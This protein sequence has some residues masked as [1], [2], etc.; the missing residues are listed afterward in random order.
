[1]KTSL[2]PNRIPSHTRKQSDGA[3]S[4]ALRLCCL[5][6][7]LSSI[8]LVVFLLQATLS[9]SSPGLAPP[10]E[11]QP[12]AL[13]NNSLHQRNLS[14]AERHTYQLDLVA[15]QFFRVILQHSGIKLT[16][17]L[18][19]PDGKLF[20]T[21]RGHQRG[22]LPISMTVEKT[23]V[24][25]LE[26]RSLEDSPYTGNYSLQ[27]VEKRAK[28][29]QDENRVAAD[30]AFAEAENDCST[31]TR[32]TLLA[33]KLQYQEAQQQ[34]QYS[35]ENKEEVPAL[36]SLG[37]VHQ[38]LGEKEQAQEALQRAL[39][40]VNEPALKIEIENDIFSLRRIDDGRCKQ[41]LESSRKQGFKRAEAL[42]LDNLGEM[43]YDAGQ[44]RLA[45]DYHLQ[46]LAL[47]RVLGERR[48]QALALW[49][50][51]AISAEFAETA[52]A[53]DFFQQAVNLY[54]VMEDKAGLAATLASMGHQE[55]WLGNKQQAMQC[56][57]QALQAAATAGDP[58]RKISISNGIGFFYTSFGEYA[59][60]LKQYEK[61]LQVAEELRR[62]ISQIGA[63]LEIG[64][65]YLFLEQPDQALA[66][67]RKAL[68]LSQKKEHHLFLPNVFLN[69]GMAY[70][71]KKQAVPA[72][73]ML[74][75]AAGLSQQNHDLRSAAR[76]LNEMG[77]IYREA[78][79]LELSR[80]THTQALAF[81]QQTHD[82]FGESQTL[83]HLAR[84]EYALGNAAASLSRL[85]SAIELIEKTRTSVMN[86]TLRA[87]YLASV[88]QSYEFLVDLLM[89]RKQA[90]GQD[91]FA[92][93]ALTSSERSRA[94]SLLD[95]LNESHT[96]IKQGV[97]ASLL[98]KERSLLKLLNNK[99]DEKMRLAGKQE[100]ELAAINQEIADINTEIEK[101][102]DKIR[103]ASPHYAA[104]RQPQ[105]LKAPEIQQLL[106]EN[107]MLLEFALGTERSYVWAVTRDSLTAVTLPQRAV[108]EKLSDEVYA[109]M[110]AP[111]SQE[112][113]LPPARLSRIK[114][115][116]ARY[117]PKAAELSQMLL[118][119][120]ADKLGNK[121]LII[122]TDGALQ[123]IPFGAL[124]EPSVVSRQSSVAKNNGQRTTDDRQPLIVNHEIS[125]LP[126]ASI[127][128]ILRKERALPPRAPTGLA[129]M[130]DSVWGFFR[131]PPPIAGALDSVAILADPVF[132][133][134]DSRVQIAANALTLPE[135]AAGQTRDIDLSDE[136]LHLNRLPET[137]SEA[138][139]IEKAAGAKAFLLKTGFAVN[140][141]LLASEELHRYGIIH[142]ATH[143]YW[144]SDRPELSGLVLSRYDP[145]GRKQD[146]F[147]RL[148]EIYNLRM[149]KELVVLSACETA[150]GKEIR[151][152]G[153][154]ALTRGFM[155]AGAARVI[156]S[157]WKVEESAT[158]DLMKVFYGKLLREKRPPA[159]ALR[160]AQI[161]M[162]RQD[163]TSAPYDWAAF[164]LQGEYR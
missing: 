89:Q 16:V 113:E 30:A 84:T 63:L 97:D 35:K 59:K 43:A 111:Q 70:R 77:Q 157:L 123:R 21:L 90:T 163:P 83:H 87:S 147:L 72:L 78:A 108:I 39:S 136:N 65:T 82:P 125:Y 86:P 67:F 100:Q 34:W 88:H 127:L 37:D 137:A 126:S 61:S 158:V 152:E 155:Y 120:L 57:K 75:Q 144:D 51:G 14:Q 149:P 50:L 66:N 124:T 112:N 99:A 47:W 9:C 29:A 62:E 107:T 48:K 52:Q 164:V 18:F 142:F 131:T 64:S 58:G 133:K 91:H 8:L 153:L 151:G 135:G 55:S 56:Y 7:R 122:V 98:E 115:A 140:R 106:D 150:L 41:W 154:M 53:Q 74:R 10:L 54:Q 40:L 32:S 96:Q 69:L 117:W 44:R 146:G 3:E 27:L 17:K 139:E 20:N 161:A 2:K 104:L 102:H 23:G 95:L 114:Q 6:G 134:D 162:W 101:V 92:G 25:R 1:M 36:L 116:N 68:T 132:E 38:Q 103:E 145:Q 5:S 31:L 119:P 80:T 93:E 138:G 42:A 85:Q 105:P 26:I 4:S 130:L 148:S 71:K 109:L 13:V 15:D 60:A 46:S 129:A 76:A 94:R 156:A 12:L 159:A 79:K 19:G 22:Q 45:R 141:A 28:Q 160:E 143:G 49:N 33:A 118:A 11:D 128:S 110:T 81:F 73:T 24:Y 121:R